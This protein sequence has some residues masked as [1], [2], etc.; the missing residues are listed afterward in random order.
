M[1]GDPAVFWWHSSEN[2]S[3]KVTPASSSGSGA[4]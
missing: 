1:S 2:L 3:P 4:S